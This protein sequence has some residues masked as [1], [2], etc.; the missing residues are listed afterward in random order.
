VQYW[1]DTNAYVKLFQPG[2]GEAR[3]RLIARL[4]T[5]GVATCS[6][7]VISSLEIHSVL[8][9][10]A[11]AQP[12]LPIACDRTP[13]GHSAPCPHQW[14]PKAIRAIPPLLIAE[15]HKIIRDAE[16]Q[17]GQLQVTVEPISPAAL[18][19]ARELIERYGPVIKIGAHDALIAGCFAK[20]ATSAGP[21]CLVTSDR[22]FKQ[23]LRSEGLP[24]YDPE[25]DSHWP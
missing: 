24:H 10:Y 7:S 20:S 21:H 5:N 18:E 8:G 14:Q 25:S 1:L 11:R 3:N 9:R 16:N 6:I 4:T 17:R 15:I 23:V 12:V 22:A 19:K 2:E 13:I